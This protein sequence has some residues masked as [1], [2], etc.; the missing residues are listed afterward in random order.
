MKKS[1]ILRITGL[2]ILLL[3][4]T[5]VLMINCADN[6]MQPWGSYGGSA[7]GDSA[8]HEGVEGEHYLSNEV[9]VKV[10]ED[11][12]P[13]DIAKKLGGTVKSEFANFDG[14][15]YVTINLNGQKVMDVINDFDEDNDIVSIQ[16][17][18]VLKKMGVQE[19]N[20]DGHMI[21]TP[22]DPDY[23]AGYEYA[24]KLVGMD[25]AWYL[26]D[27]LQGDDAS[28]DYENDPVGYHGKKG[29]EEILA[30]IIDTGI[31]GRHVEFE[32]MM[33]EGK[34][35]YG[36]QGMGNDVNHPI[37]PPDIIPPK[38]DSDGDIHGT[39]VAGLV[40]AQGDNGKGGANGAWNI[41]VNAHRVFPAGASGAADDPIIRSIIDA[42]YYTGTNINK[43]T[44]P[45]TINRV[46]MNMS[47]GGRFWDQGQLDAVNW[48]VRRNATIMA[49]AGNDT[50]DY[51]GFPA[52]YPGVIAVGATDGYDRPAFFTS[53]GIFV[54]I[55][56]PGVNMW[57]T[58]AKSN[59]EMINLSGT[60]MATPFACGIAALVSSAALDPRMRA[61]S[62]A[63]D[64]TI[65]RDEEVGRVRD[66]PL[67]L[68]AADLKS[69]LETTAVD[70]GEPGYDTTYGHGRI[71]CYEA[72]RMAMDYDRSTQCKYGHVRVYVT[73]RI[74]YDEFGNPV[75]DPDAEISNAEVF[76]FDSKGRLRAVTRTVK[77]SLSHYAGTIPFGAYFYNLPANEE[78]TIQ[79]SHK[80][81]IKNCPGEGCL[82]YP[83]TDRNDANFKSLIVA[84]NCTD[85]NDPQ[86]ITIEF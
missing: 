27:E 59:T 34:G 73:D 62:V 81:S 25:R 5:T 31:N 39:H 66:Q 52:A 41:T 84:P 53:K 70:K 72:V 6:P 71:N 30:T 1:H 47:L 40:A 85:L 76:V 63:A 11:Y 69:I 7:L 15:R 16:P 21:Y 65:S 78:Y 29:R 13:H 26:F 23:L 3:G 68:N 58:F 50:V 14:F 48:A 24:P 56:S 8:W 75:T 18:F 17:N 49:A 46:I 35:Y 45:Q 37:N 32:G 9:I 2:I 61:Y 36:I 80:G 82:E 54:S 74:T 77:R 79:V 19:R 42:A 4:F 86:K 57:S 64:G 44:G 28:I 83:V 51:W 33:G 67:S 22:D 55:G 20:A 12:E 38:W 60:S 43:E 10:I